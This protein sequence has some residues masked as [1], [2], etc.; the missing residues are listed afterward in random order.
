MKFWEPHNMHKAKE[1]T[2][3]HKNNM[4]TPNETQPIRVAPNLVDQSLILSWSNPPPSKPT[5]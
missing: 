4:W 1:G 2:C 3:L 5:Q